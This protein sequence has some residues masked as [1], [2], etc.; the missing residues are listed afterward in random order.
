MNALLKKLAVFVILV[1]ISLATSISLALAQGSVLT[2]PP[3]NFELVQGWYQGRQ[4]FYYDFGA[5]TRATL[6]GGQ[7]IRAPMYVLIAGFD[8]DGNPQTVEG[9]HPIVDVIPG[10]PGYSDLWQVNYVTVPG[11]YQSNT[12]T[13]V[14]QILNGDYELTV[15]GLLK[16]CPIV[17]E[18][19]TLDEGGAPL[20]GRW[21]KGQEVFCFDFGSNV[22]GTASLDVF[23]TGF[24]DDGNPQFV[25]G[26]RNIVYS[27]PGDPG[28]SA[29]WFVNMVVV[30]EDYQPN[31]ITS[32]SQV[33]GSDYE[34]VHPGLLVNCP[35]IRTLDATPVA[36]LPVTGEL[37]GDRIELVWWILAAG[38]ALT[39][40]GL[41]LSWMRSTFN[42]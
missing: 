42:V 1:A 39:G 6:D 34:I 29:F 40:T 22:N 18:G 35:I 26:Q 37:G 16:N 21:Y 2:D 33:L 7:V 12:I 23:I 41:I 27:I 8:G 20:V 24:D 11:D 4:T 5:T 15:P 14:D 10:D 9:Q 31:T 3:E 32:A 30:P 28:Y 38:V 17:P 25:Q 13:A 19:S 36:E